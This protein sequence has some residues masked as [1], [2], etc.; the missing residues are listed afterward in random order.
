MKFEIVQEY[1]FIILYF[2]V[3]GQESKDMLQMS[4]SG[5][6]CCTSMCLIVNLMHL[7]GN[8]FLSRTRKFLCDTLSPKIHLYKML[9]KCFVEKITN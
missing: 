9:D 3:N 6:F 7:E 1:I 4:V 5:N 2:F 8:L